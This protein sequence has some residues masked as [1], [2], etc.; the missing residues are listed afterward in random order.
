MNKKILVVVIIGIFFAMTLIATNVAKPAA[1]PQRDDPYLSYS[2]IVE[3]GG[4][5][6]DGT[7]VVGGFTEVSGL[8]FETQFAEYRNGNE[9]GRPR[10][11]S[12]YRTISDITLKRG[13]VGTT[14]LFDWVKGVSN[15]AHDY[16]DVTITLRDESHEDKVK[17]TLKD[18]RPIKWEGP[19]FNA[20]GGD[21]IAME[22]IT[23][24]AEDITME[25]IK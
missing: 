18:C 4:E 2:F 15:G 5:T 24:A 16:R 9:D 17:W 20:T 19:T 8:S 21:Q 14:D 1:S 12:G 11:I 25:I 13:V 6:G 7:T 22:E 10:K 3:I 23:L